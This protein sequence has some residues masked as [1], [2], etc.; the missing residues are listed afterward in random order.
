MRKATEKKGVMNEII[1][2]GV[3][4]LI[5]SI[6]FGLT[7]LFVSSLKDE[8]RTTTERTF[9]ITNE[10][11]AYLNSSNSGGYILSLADSDSLSR[12]FAITSVYNN[13]DGALIGSGN[14]S[15]S[16]TG[17]VIN[18]TAAVFDDVNVTYTY[19]SASSET[20]YTAVNDTE[21][22]GATVVSY[23]PLVFLSLIFGAIL[24]LV[25]KIILPYFN[26]GRSMQGF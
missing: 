21:A 12:N 1:S 20:S 16:A 25:L 19:R 26:L 9:T 23:L 18:S 17:L 11:G 22:A 4:I 13:S 3:L 15:V 10:T 14:Y 8:V 7:F 5:V 6:L 2:V 24:T